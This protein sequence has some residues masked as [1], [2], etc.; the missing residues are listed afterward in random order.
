[1]DAAIIEKL[2]G[3]LL[4]SIISS[5]SAWFGVKFIYEKRMAVAEKRID[6]L[7]KLS[8]EAFYSSQRAE[9][10]AIEAK[11]DIRFFVQEIKHELAEQTIL[12]S[13]LAEKIETERSELVREIEKIERLDAHIAKM[14]DIIITKLP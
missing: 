8:F 13:R 10:I 4:T 11:T 3:W 5:S 2:F 7:K 9:K 12:I 1:M 6:Y 14:V